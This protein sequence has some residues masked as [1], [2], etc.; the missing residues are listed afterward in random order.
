MTL[1]LSEIS[2]MS[3]LFLDCE[4]EDATRTLISVGL[5]NENGER[6]FYEVLPHSHVRDEWVLANVIP[7][8]QQAP[9]TFEEYQKRLGK[10]LSQFPGVTIVSDHI[11]DVAYYSRSLDQGSGKWVMT[12]PLNFIVD[13]EL[14]AKKSKI[15]HNAI[16]DARAVRDSFLVKEGLTPLTHNGL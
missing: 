8:L 2:K 1:F 12:Q 16:F 6:E 3:L 10:F 14:S 15:L 4:F 9:V 7:I 11:N 5:T 13:D